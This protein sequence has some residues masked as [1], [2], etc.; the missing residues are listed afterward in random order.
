MCRM[1]ALLQRHEPLPT[2]LAQPHEALR[3]IG[4]TAIRPVLADRPAFDGLDRERLYLRWE[5]RLYGTVAKGALRDV[6]LFHDE[7]VELAAGTAAPAVEAARPEPENVTA[8]P[9]HEGAPMRASA[10]RHDDM[11]ERARELVIVGARLAELAARSDDPQ[12]VPSLRNSSASRPACAG[13]PCR[14]ACPPSAQSPGAFGGWCTTGPR[15]A[16]SPSN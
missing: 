12:L 5:V 15:S 11:M 3:G 6:F 1:R 9:A 2:Y 4:A 14:S 8:A 16:A 10:E 13:P 7:A